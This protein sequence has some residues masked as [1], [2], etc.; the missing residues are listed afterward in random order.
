[1]KKLRLILSG[2]LISGTGI[3]EII[4]DYPRFIDFI[5]ILICGVVLLT[6]IPV[7]TRQM[8]A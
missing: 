4:K 5:I 6:F 2:I 7:L 3:L 8:K 1:M